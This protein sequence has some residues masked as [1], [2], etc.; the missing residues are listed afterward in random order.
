MAKILA[1]YRQLAN[2]IAFNNFLD[3]QGAL[4]NRYL[5][6]DQFDYDWHARKLT[7]E[8]HFRALVLLHATSY[9]S[10]RDLQWAAENDVL[11]KS[12]G[13]GF[14][15][16]VP[17]LTT[18]NAQRPLEPFLEMLGQVMD[19]VARLPHRRLRSLPQDKWRAIVS[20]LS[21]IDIFD[22][23]RIKLPASLAQWA[24]T[25][26]ENASFKLQLKLEG[27][28]GHF[29]KVMLTPV[30]GNDNPYF[31]TL[32]DLHDDAGRIYLFDAGYFN[33][34]TYH[35]ISQSH[36]FFVTKLHSNIQPHTVCHRLVQKPLL[37]NGYVV[38]EDRY[39]T[40]NGDDTNWFRCLRVR[41]TT[42]KVITILTNLL[43]LSAEQSLPRSI[44]VC[45]LYHYRWSIEI[46]FRWLKDLLQ[47][48]HFISRDPQ[49]IVRQVV[50]AL[51]VWGLLV[52][53]N[54]QQNAF[55]P[56]MLWRQLQADIHQA[57][58]ELGR[59][60]GHD[61]ARNKPLAQE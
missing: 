55:S 57:I 5:V 60:V 10:A 42:E 44:G 11:F 18:A 47:L 25:R 32:L 46:V 53:A 23:T 2:P 20:L 31:E 22:S 59:R 21:E 41:L 9:E 29:K 48:S 7:F 45:L 34:E 33:V 54:Q 39:V 15:I 50:T 28:S 51:I 6:A 37:P 40:L 17:G 16:S 56:K 12:L 8:P 1:E 26:E 19:M 4:R 24:Q 27:L 38:E 61:E 49:G 58:F 13:A 36:N 3:G 35:T 30:E 52:I 14:E 43:W